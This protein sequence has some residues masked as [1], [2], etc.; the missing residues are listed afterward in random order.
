MNNLNQ[1]NEIFKNVLLLEDE[2]IQDATIDNVLQWDSLEHF[3]LVTEIEE[4]FNIKF[5]NEEIADFISYKSGLEILRKH[6]AIE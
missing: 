2:T 6:G 4:K 5:K 3:H 1:Y